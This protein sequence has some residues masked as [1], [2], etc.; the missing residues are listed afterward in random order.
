MPSGEEWSRFRF[1]ARRVKEIAIQDCDYPEEAFATHP[2]VFDILR[3]HYSGPILPN[4]RRLDFR[5][6]D[7]PA[8]VTLFIQPSLRSIEFIPEFVDVAQDLFRAIETKAPYLETIALSCYEEFIGEICDRF[9]KAICTM[10]HLRC[11]NFMCMPLL[12]EALIHLSSLPHL[13]MFA[14]ELRE[15]NAAVWTSPL[16]GRFPSLCKLHVTTSLADIAALASFL[17]SLDKT[18]LVNLKIS[19]CAQRPLASV[20]R[21]FTAIGQFNRKRLMKCSM[22]FSETAANAWDESNLEFTTISPV[23]R[24]RQMVHFELRAMPLELTTANVQELGAAWPCL[25]TLSCGSGSSAHRGLSVDLVDLKIFAQRC[26]VLQSLTIEFRPL[27]DGWSWTWTPASGSWPLPSLAEYLSLQYS[28]VPRA[29][30]QGVLMFLA[31]IFPIA[32]TNSLWDSRERPIDEG[33]AILAE[34][35]KAKNELINEESVREASRLRTLMVE[36]PELDEF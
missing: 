13:R 24:L 36:V 30:A 11:L 32:R 33:R 34:I 21:L 3:E 6:C 27:P 35:C 20:G 1:F 9:S 25:R 18:N 28:R 31:V 23:L 29:A 8:N 5:A 26:I 7:D 15:E 2:H 14:L 19:C 22:D 4:L 12:N 17:E 10:Q 16:W